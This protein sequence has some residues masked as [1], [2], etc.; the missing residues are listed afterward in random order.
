MRHI[1]AFDSCVWNMEYISDIKLLENVQRRW[2]KR[3]DG[4]ENLTY[5]QRLKDLNF[6]S[7][8]GKFLRA[9]IIKCWKVFRSKYGICMEDIFVSARSD[10]FHGLVL[11]SPMYYALAGDC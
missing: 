5:S 8:E 9:D 7:V 6:F 2:T 11:K 1:L 3:I 10:I 4:F